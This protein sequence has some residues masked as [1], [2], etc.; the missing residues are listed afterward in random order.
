VDNRD[1]EDQ[2]LVSDH[3]DKNQVRDSHVGQKLT[4]D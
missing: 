2:V 1:I 4:L 3:T